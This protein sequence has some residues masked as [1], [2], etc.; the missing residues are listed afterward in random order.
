MHFDNT[1]FHQKPYPNRAFDKALFDLSVFQFNRCATVPTDQE[2]AIMI[3]LGMRA[4][5][6]CIAAFNL[7]HQ[8]LRRQEIKRSVYGR[9]GNRSSRAGPAFQRV[10]ELVSADRAG[11]LQKQL[12]HVPPQR[13]HPR[14]ALA[15]DR[16]R[17][18]K[19]VSN[20]SALAA[21]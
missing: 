20:R 4:G 15:A 8:P 17:Q 5:D 1:S 21:A 16:L 7:C 19:P 12:Q 3:L 2:D 9:R 14:A 18:C 13:C 10:D 6:V 11:A